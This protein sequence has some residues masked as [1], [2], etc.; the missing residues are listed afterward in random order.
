LSLKNTVLP[1]PPNSFASSQHY[2]FDFAQQV[3]K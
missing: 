1:Q 3:R 2:S